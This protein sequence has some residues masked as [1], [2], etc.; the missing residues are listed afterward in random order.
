MIVRGA[1]VKVI[2]LAER[3]VCAPNIFEAP[4]ICLLAR[5]SDSLRQ[6]RDTAA[7]EKREAF[8]LAREFQPKPKPN[9]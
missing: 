6:K 9:R 1:C 5:A 7:V 8:M 3:T 2:P 4:V